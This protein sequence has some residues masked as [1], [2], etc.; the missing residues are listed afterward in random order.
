MPVCQR[1]KRH[2]LG[3]TSVMSDR[4]RISSGNTR[5]S[6]IRSIQQFFYQVLDVFV[7]FPLLIYELRSTGSAVSEAPVAQEVLSGGTVLYLQDLEEQKRTKYKINVTVLVPYTRSPLSL[8]QYSYLYEYSYGIM[9]CGS[10]AAVAPW[11]LI[12]AYPHFRRSSRVDA[13][14]WRRRRQIPPECH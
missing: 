12:V 1:S 6:F 9:L 8:L 7:E 5:W 2:L 14:S 4:K 13:D 11:Q 3:I 10:A